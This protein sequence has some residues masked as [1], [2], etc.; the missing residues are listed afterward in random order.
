MT[1]EE[2]SQSAPPEPE[3]QEEAIERTHVT[4][5]AS[6][7]EDI[8]RHGSLASKVLTGLALLI[9]GGIAAI[10]GGQRVAP[11]LPAGLA[12]VAAFFAPQDTGKEDL[13]K[14]ISEQLAATTHPRLAE[15]EK[16][17]E[18]ALLKI[19]A[20][21][22]MLSETNAEILLLSRQGVSS[23]LI[24]DLQKNTRRLEQSFEV[25]KARID[26]LEETGLASSDLSAEG[27]AAA[28]AALISMK[29]NL[30]KVRQ[31][32]DKLQTRMQDATLDAENQ[33]RLAAESISKMQEDT[34]DRIKNMMEM[35]V[36]A[37]IRGA[38]D[39]GA[40]FDDLIARWS[41]PIPPKLLAVAQTGVPTY[42]EL[43]EEFNDLSL[44]ALQ[45]DIERRRE[46]GEI[47]RL[48]AFLQSQIEVRSLEP[49]AGDSADA[50]LS[51][52]GASFRAGDI[53]GA[54]DEAKALPSGAAE[55][56]ASWLEK[57]EMRDAA[58]ALLERLEAER[59]ETRVTQ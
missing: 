59:D 48:S 56:M 47:T 12:P 22:K 32:Q 11:H 6:D 23:E 54:R 31:E 27:L 1:K 17:H 50:V 15:L 18:A 37:E 55:I 57:M 14:I 38:F 33:S 13:E 40:P 42:E 21:E 5:L 39:K 53:E 51:R 10:W 44:R 24:D 35:Q 52:I 29:E 19:D 16:K 30:E 20:H 43:D 7:K 34:A 3:P 45:K 25:L 49:R 58:Y 28:N 36:L 26:Q 8:D 9:V 46:S 4:D 2:T 41:G